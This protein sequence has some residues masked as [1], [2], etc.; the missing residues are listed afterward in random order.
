MSEISCTF[1]RRSL[2]IQDTKSAHKPVTVDTTGLEACTFCVVDSISRGQPWLAKASFC[3][4]LGHQPEHFDRVK[5]FK[6]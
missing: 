3:I 5:P 4:L 1:K 2:R 6:H